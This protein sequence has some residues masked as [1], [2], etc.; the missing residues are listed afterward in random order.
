MVSR[1]ASKGRDFSESDKEE[2]RAK[3]IELIGLV[4]PAYREA[5]MRGQVELSTT[6]FYHPILPLVCD[7]DIPR[8]GIRRRRCRDELIEGRKMRG[9]NCGGRGNITNEFLV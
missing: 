1:L 2:L 4:L 9:S 7:S 3:E 8:V 5:A 6:P